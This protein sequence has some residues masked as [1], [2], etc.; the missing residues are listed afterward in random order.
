MNRDD[1]YVHKLWGSLSVFPINTNTQQTIVIE[2]PDY[3]D[4][5]SVTIECR[6]YFMNLDL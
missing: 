2:G 1:R 5:N 3:A 6:L 4:R